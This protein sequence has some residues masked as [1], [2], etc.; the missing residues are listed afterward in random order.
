[1]TRR[2]VGRAMR[3][4]SHGRCLI[5]GAATLPGQ[6]IGKCAGTGWKRAEV[7]R[8]VHVACVVEPPEGTQGELWPPREQ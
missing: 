7:G 1:M 2:T 6:F 4:R 8:W 5:C 3:A